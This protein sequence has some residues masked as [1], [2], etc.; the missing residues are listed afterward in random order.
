M[1]YQKFNILTASADDGVYNENDI[2]T[3]YIFRNKPAR[4]A[5]NTFI[6]C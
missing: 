5:Y 2:C 6:G 1:A 3:D 4:V